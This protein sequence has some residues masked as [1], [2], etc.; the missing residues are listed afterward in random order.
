MNEQTSGPDQAFQPSQPEPPAR[1]PRQ[2][3]FNL[4]PALLATL[5]LLVLIFVVQSALPDDWFQWFL[6]NFGFIPLR[7]AVSLAEQGPQLYWTPVTYS[8]LHGS[9]E[10]ILFN[11]L[12]LMAFG[13]PVIRRIGIGRYLTFWFLSSIASAALHAALNWGDP[14]L[15]IGASGVI[16]GLMGAACR[17]AF[18]AD[19]RPG[20]PAHLN[21]RL[22]IAQTFRSRTVIA[23][24]L[25][26]L[27]G[28]AL[29][30]VGVPLIGDGSQAIAWDAHIGGFVFGFFLFP[31]FDRALPPSDESQDEPSVLQS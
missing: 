25:F 6:F 27:F 26:W 21:P 5:L 22:S 11:G 23:F 20:R 13:A 9:I 28:N 12:W 19:A 31:L 14:T 24:T 29:I 16:S 30:A 2:P 3:V 17:F 7:Y 4:P 18:P 8:L 15:L 10:H 1:P